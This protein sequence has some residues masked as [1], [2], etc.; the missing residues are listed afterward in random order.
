VWPKTAMEKPH[1]L[2]IN[3]IIIIIDC[4]FDFVFFFAG[5][6]E[7]DAAPGRVA[8]QAVVVADSA[9][10]DP[11]PVASRVHAVV[12]RH[13]AGG[14][15]HGQLHAVLLPHVPARPAVLPERR[16]AGGRGV[17]GA[18]VSRVPVAAVAVA[19]QPELRDRLHTGGHVQRAGDVRAVAHVPEHRARSRAQRHRRRRRVRHIRP[20]RDARLSGR[21]HVVLLPVPAAR[22]QGR[23]RRRGVRRVGRLTGAHPLPSEI[24]YI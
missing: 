24:N 3:I 7:N 18:R 1:S 19:A 13:G 5:G 6:R 10:P 8:R 20:V 11:R 17:P 14:V 4:I 21:Q 15:G 16:A 22:Q 12:G 9:G 23:A 2:A